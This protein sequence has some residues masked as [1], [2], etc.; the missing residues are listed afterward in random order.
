MPEN[1]P[2]KVIGVLDAWREERQRKRALKS[3][4]PF[5][6]EHQ[7]LQTQSQGHPSPPVL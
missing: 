7:N 1:G 5:A 3:G 4:R 6:H 2:S